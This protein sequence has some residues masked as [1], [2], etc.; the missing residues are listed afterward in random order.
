MRRVFLSYS[1][2]ESD[3]VLAEHLKDLLVSR[4][5]AVVTGE[6]L[7]GEDVGP[8]LQQRIRS[9][10][11]LVALMT[12][13]EQ[14]ANG[15]Y[16]T[17]AWVSSEFDHAVGVGLP[18][19][20]LIEPDVRVA[21]AVQSRE[22]VLLDRANLTPALLK[23]N[24]SLAEWARR[25]GRKR[26]LIKNGVLVCLAFAIGIAVAVL[27]GQTRPAMA[28]EPHPHLAKAAREYRICADQE[29]GGFP[30]KPQANVLEQYCSALSKPALLP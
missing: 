9:C 16:T 15:G 13:R 20:A 7:H 5:I 28:T 8:Q 24:R 11:A 19:L 12:N 29:T 21:G 23:V 4:D 14:L 1:F 2:S 26:E 22:H 18:T 30:C 3:R 10:D 6:D 17:H 27:V 25:W